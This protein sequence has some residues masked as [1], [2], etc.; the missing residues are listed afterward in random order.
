MLLRALALIL[1]L[2]VPASAATR[3]NV[4]IGAD[5]N[6]VEVHKTL[7]G[8]GF[9]AAPSTPRSRRRPTP[10]ASRGTSTWRS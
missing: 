3:L 5:V 8:P 6:V 7:L 1:A 2:I 4:A 10:A 9:R